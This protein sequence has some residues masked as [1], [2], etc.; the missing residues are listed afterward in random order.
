MA[1]PREIIKG[2]TGRRDQVRLTRAASMNTIV[3]GDAGREK[4]SPQPSLDDDRGGRRP[5]LDDAAGGIPRGPRDAAAGAHA[6]LVV[7][8]HVT[9]GRDGDGFG[10]RNAARARPRRPLPR[11]QRGVSFDSARG[12]RGPEEP[13]PPN[14]R[15]SFDG[16]RR[17][18][19]DSDACDDGDDQREP[20]SPPLT[21][22]SAHSAGGGASAWRRRPN[23]AQADS[24]QKK[25][26]PKDGPAV[27]F[28]R[29]AP[30]SFESVSFKPRG[31]VGT[32]RRRGRR[33]ARARA[34]RRDR[35][36][37]VPSSRSVL[38]GQVV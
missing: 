38:S 13:P 26:G 1:L 16:H 25:D 18:S 29:P 11:L 23:M 19:F 36:S 5:S 30:S 28:S 12:L 21:F 17:R 32:Q 34:V 4:A 15:R 24:F 8:G 2:S 3:E 33:L 14:R 10:D 20:L 35:S 7:F 27:S 22:A 37:R 6:P 9:P 31:C